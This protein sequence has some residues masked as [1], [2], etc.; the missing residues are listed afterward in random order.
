MAL[1]TSQ[2]KG[3]HNQAALVPRQHRAGVPPE[4]SVGMRDMGTMHHNPCRCQLRL[5]A[6]TSAGGRLASVDG[7]DLGSGRRQKDEQIAT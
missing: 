4:D 7:P 1:P 5:C 3:A 2:E 6:I